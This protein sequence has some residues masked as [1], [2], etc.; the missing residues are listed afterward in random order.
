[1]AAPGGI[2]RK[3]QHRGMSMA[4]AKR[5]WRM[6]AIG[7]SQLGVAAAYAIVYSDAAWRRQ[8]GGGGW[9]RRIGCNQ[10][11]NRQIMAV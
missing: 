9:R 6:A 5:Q 1:M 10:A 4:A 2:E 8:H 3:W 7:S 11:I